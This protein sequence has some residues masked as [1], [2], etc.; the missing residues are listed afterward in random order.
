[1]AWLPTSGLGWWRPAAL[2]GHSVPGTAVSQ[3]E[4]EVGF[5]GEPAC[6][7]TAL[8]LRLSTEAGKRGLWEGP[9]PQSTGG[10]EGVRRLRVGKELNV[11]VWDLGC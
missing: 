6:E 10:K 5:V 9:S 4:A 7:R 3:G 2:R 1:M 11:D 8:A